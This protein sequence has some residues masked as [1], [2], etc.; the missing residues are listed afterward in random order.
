MQRGAVLGA[1]Q[2]SPLGKLASS[3]IKRHID[4]KL[5]ADAAEHSPAQMVQ[6]P[7]AKL[8][9]QSCTK[10]GGVQSYLLETHRNP[11]ASTV[12]RFHSKGLSA[13]PD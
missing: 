2:R 6:A 10:E 9:P 7:P 3:H 13:L 4:T 8:D 12:D 1:Q 5:P 11:R